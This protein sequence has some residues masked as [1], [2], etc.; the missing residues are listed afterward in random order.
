MNEASI[1]ILIITIFS[2]DF[3]FENLLLWLNIN[4]QK[5][6]LPPEL[7]GIYSKDKYLKSLAYQKANT[8][9]SFFTGSLSFIITLVLISGGY[10]GW[11][12]NNLNLYIS[13]P[14]LHALGFFALI[15]FASD[16]ITL[17]FQLYSIFGIEEKFGFNKTT[18]KLFFADKIKTLLL[19]IVLGGPLGYLFLYL[20]INIGAN[21]WI[22]FLVVFVAFMVLMNL[23]YTSLIMPLFNKLTPLEDGELRK[24]IESYCQKVNFPLK[25]LFVIDGSKRSAKANA[26]FSGFGKTKKIVLYDTLIQN[27]TQEELVAVLAHEVGHY[28][29]N[30]IP[31]NLI[32]SVLQM[33]FVLF[34]L[35]LFIFNPILSKALGAEGLSIPLNLMAFSFLYSP[36]SM[37]SGL[38][39]S[40][41][42][43]KHEY[44]ADKF[45]KDTYN[46]KA[47]ETA[48]KTLSSDSLS[49]LTPHPWY[50]F[51][52][53]SHPT[54]LQRLK[55]LN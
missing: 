4:H 46:G 45:A 3:I 50:V 27:H 15:S 34:M 12:N 55:A 14:I 52:N 20:V 38:L 10:F 30:H 53:Y 31:L 29:K 44:E 2:A 37:I 21:F 54:L 28:K 32:L 16:L 7:K 39:M 47:L 48:L 11:I 49:N 35:S 13:D 19:G 24:A 41:I 26:F 6:V 51:F 1:L 22:Y 43:R 25:N 40:I 5:R 36:I 8:Y 33:A 42:S 17:P 18:L 9:F 23:F